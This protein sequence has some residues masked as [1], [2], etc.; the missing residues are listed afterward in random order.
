MDHKPKYPEINIWMFIND[1]NAGMPS[2]QLAKIFKLKTINRVNNYVNKLRK[3]GHTLNARDHTNN[4][5]KH[6]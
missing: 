2:Q 6:K 1:W 3:E 5:R 4:N